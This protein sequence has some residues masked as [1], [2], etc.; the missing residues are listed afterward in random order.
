MFQ[1]KI[2][3]FPVKSRDKALPRRIPLLHKSIPNPQFQRIVYYSIVFP[4]CHFTANGLILRHLPQ[5]LERCILIQQ[6]QIHSVAVGLKHIPDH[7][8]GILLVPGQKKMPDNHAP[9]HHTILIKDRLSTV[10]AISPS[11]PF[12]TS[13]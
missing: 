2:R 5:P 9:L 3:P 12:A 11:A 7:I 1:L 4:P 13:G 8:P 10:S 6:A